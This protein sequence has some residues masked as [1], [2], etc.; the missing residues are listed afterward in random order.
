MAVHLLQRKSDYLH[1]GNIDNPKLCHADRSDQISVWNPKFGQGYQQTIPLRDDLSLI[2]FDDRLHSPLLINQPEQTEASLKFEFQLVGNKSQTSSFTPQIAPASLDMRHGQQR[3]FRIEVSVGPSALMTYYQRTAEHLSPQALKSCNYFIEISHYGFFGSY[4]PSPQKA[5]D[6]ILH[7]SSVSPPPMEKITEIIC[8]NP[9][10]LG[11][12]LTTE[13]TMTPAM[14]RIIHQILGCPYGGRSRRTYLE[15]KAL[16]LVDLKLNQLEQW[17]A[18]SYPLRFEELNNIREASKILASQLQAPPSVEQL[19]RRV[20]LN[21]FKLNHGF[22]HIFGTTP[23]R[24]LRTCRLEL[25]SHLLLTSRETVDMI[26]YRV[27]YNN[28]SRFAAAFRK[29]FGL[30]PKTFQIQM[31]TWDHALRDRQY[32]S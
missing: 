21:R 31:S 20:G 2:I 30:N 16:E 24:Y 8:S 14:N 3:K 11:H 12:R 19:A 9:Q 13:R 5:L 29:E 27:G 6:Q 25:A 1:S 15:K 4:A 32:A 18:P 10:F 23:F 26:A 22:H 28:R 7:R 17:S